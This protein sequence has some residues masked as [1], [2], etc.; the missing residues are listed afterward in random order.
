M[1]KSFACISALLVL[2][3]SARAQDAFDLLR[4]GDIPALKALIEKSPASLA[5]K[6]EAGSTL[7]HM[8]AAYDRSEAVAALLKM[9][10]SVT[11]RDSYG[12]TALILCARERGQAAT[13]RLLI[14]AGSDVNAVDKFGSSALDLAAWRGKA[15]VI[16]LLLEK[17][18]KVPESGENWKEMLTQAASKGLSVLFGR[19]T[20]G[21]DA[22]KAAF[23]ANPALL[24]EAAAGGSSK[25]VAALVDAGM[26]AGAAD[27]FGWT[28]LHYA[29]RDG[30]IDAVRI[31]IERG[32][33]LDARSLMGQTAYN[34]AVE[35]KMEPVAQF[36]GEKGADKSAIR[37]PVLKG[38]YLGQK[39]P[40][41]KAEMF[42][43]GIISSVWGLHSTAV[44]SP[45]GNEVYWAPMV[46]FPGELYS[47]GGLVMMKRVDGVWTAPA[48]A[49]FSGPETR[50][51]VPFFSAD[52]KRL[53]FLSV[54]PLPGETGQKERIWF[55]DRMEAGWSEPRPLDP[56]V[57]D[58][59]M[60]WSF[61]L[62]RTGD[63]YFGGQGRDSRG[64]S[65]IYRARFVDGKFEKPVN[66][67]DPISSKQEETTP[68]VAPD[69]SYL[70]FSRQF[71][72]W[73]SFRQADASW[74]APV[75]LGPEVNTPAIELGPEVT[76]DGK[77]LFFLSQRDGESWAYWVSASV[78]EKA[79]PFPVLKGDYLGQREPGLKPEIFVPGAVSTKK[80]E[81][82]SV[83]TPDGKEFYFTVQE[84]PRGW[85][86]MVMKR[87]GDVWTKPR[88]ADFSGIWSDVD[89]FLTPDGKTMYF[90]SNRPLDGKGA[91]QNNFD[92]WMVERKGEGWSE[93]RNMGAP[94]NSPENEFYPSVAKDGT[95]VFQSWR[96]GSKGGRDIYRARLTD[97]VYKTVENVG[98]PI[99]TDLAEGDALISPDGDFIIL[100]VERP[101][102]FGAGDLC[103]SFRG[104]DGSWSEPRN[105]GGAIN[106]KANENCPI[107]SP[108]GKFFFYTSAGD[109]YWVSSKVIDEFRPGKKAGKG[110]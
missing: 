81:L 21:A 20:S 73:V 103:V 76:A 48:P 19:L 26:A 24:Y 84:P 88:P 36:L 15:E 94:I 3:L 89:H 66:M 42:G 22:L 87:E 53:Y 101:D 67:G 16:D 46:M 28:P 30:R 62:E 69:G 14:E 75:K 86:I 50:D 100:S 1:K 65:D 102:G 79:R 5:A 64:M 93:A 43:L 4:K 105:M 80:R 92:I 35:R 2:A 54:R 7:L 51:D 34:V 12:R 109:I 58:H 38:D 47:R 32:A 95:M 108:D 8:A 49:P 25:I 63:L 13:A 91:T 57:N 77:Y 71:D 72:I 68:F 10:G 23:E 37:F 70:V 40:G 39:P 99:S 17:G 74:G 110:F 82:N 45:D 97:G 107:I 59:P 11:E 98:P 60:H 85:T 27:R 96:T 56:A 83:F 61:S 6:N 29:A 90:C 104:K 41:E 78:I 52:G 44:F 18:A 31:L 106:T 9:G 55:V 33:P